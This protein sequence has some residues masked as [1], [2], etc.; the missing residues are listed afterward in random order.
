M[1]ELL[2][3]P[4]R[5]DQETEMAVSRWLKLAETVLPE[6]IQPDCAG[7]VQAEADVTLAPR[8]RLKKRAG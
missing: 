1:G 4:D 3:M 8:P 5:L 2:R 6:G 7:E